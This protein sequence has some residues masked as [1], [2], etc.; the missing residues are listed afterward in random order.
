MTGRGK[1]SA[2]HILILSVLL[3]IVS[4]SCDIVFNGG[5]AIQEVFEDDI[6]KDGVSMHP[7]ENL[8]V[9]ISIVPD[10]VS[11]VHVS[12]YKVS[13]YR[14]GDGE[15]LASTEIDPS[16]SRGEF[17][18]IPRAEYRMV[19]IAVSDAGDEVARRSVVFHLTSKG[20]F[21]EVSFSSCNHV[22]T[23]SE[24]ETEMFETSSEGHRHICLLCHRAIG[25]IVAHSWVKANDADFH[26]DECSICHFN[27]GGRQEHDFVDGRCVVCGRAAQDNPS[28]GFDVVEDN[29]EPRGDVSVFN[30]G[31]SAWT[32]VFED[33]ASKEENKVSDL[34]WCLD[35]E[36]VHEVD[37]RF[38]FVLTTSS[39]RSYTVLCVFSNGHGYGSWEKTI[40]G[41]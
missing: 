30:D 8:K 33:K 40:T 38:K 5:T 34:F 17:V 9:S 20:A 1:A 37:G 41:F 15:A 10:E 27:G 7:T 36:R 12:A 6:V 2:I 14:N 19:V 4:V 16:L 32:F 26:W 21:V 22:F 18:G 23:D 24:H 35:G 11:G 13:L 39:R 28:S 25:D 3:V 29:P 31:G